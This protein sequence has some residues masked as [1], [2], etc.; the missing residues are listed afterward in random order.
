MVKRSAFFLVLVIF[1]STFVLAEAINIEFPLGD[2]FKAGEDITLKVS[3]FDDQNIPF[4]ESV[5]LTFED[6]EKISKI[7]KTIFS[8]EIVDIDLGEGII[9]G[10]WTVTAKYQDIQA[11]EIITIEIEELAK[12]EI[13]DDL[14]IITN[15]GNTRYSKTVQIVIG[16]TVGIKELKLDVGESVE[17]RLIAP[18]GIYNLRV[19]DGVTSIKKGSVSL[20]GNVIGI[21]DERIVGSNTLTGGIKPGGDISSTYL[22]SN[23]F[24]YVFILVIFGATIL[25]AIERNY[26]RKVRA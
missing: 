10:F 8:K 17:L 21:L 13:N 23:K 24:V 1:L 9:S 4:K 19:S 2:S 15:V 12:F 7:E 11:S 3:L 18:E 6:A 22:R 16:D 5:E 20:T 26:R 25:L 14:L